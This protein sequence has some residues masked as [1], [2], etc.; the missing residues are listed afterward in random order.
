LTDEAVEDHPWNFEQMLAKWVLI[1]NGIDE[2][3]GWD[4]LAKLFE[5]W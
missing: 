1:I 3:D 4:F 5:R 2:I